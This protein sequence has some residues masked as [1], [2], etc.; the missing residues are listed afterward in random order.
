MRNIRTTFL[1]SFLC[2]LFFACV[3]NV[4]SI[5]TSPTV[6]KTISSAQYATKSIFPT[7]TANLNLKTPP[8][9]PGNPIPIPSFTPCLKPSAFTGED[10]FIGLIFPPFPCGIVDI[11]SMLQIDKSGKHWLIQ[12]SGA[13]LNRQLW[14]AEEIKRD[15]MWTGEWRVIDI[16]TLSNYDGSKE[17]A[18]VPYLCAMN[19]VGDEE[20]FVYA[21]IT[22]KVLITR[23]ITN[24]LIRKAWRLNFEEGRIEDIP[25]TGIVC[26]ADYSLE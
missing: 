7:T 20:I 19:F 2:I 1:L 23:L 17:Y 15:G 16:K 3:S 4:K 12:I 9:T 10:Q 26:E 24:D 22:D 8:N 13:D 21:E 11:N 25:T 18:Y 5:Q 6:V 14:L